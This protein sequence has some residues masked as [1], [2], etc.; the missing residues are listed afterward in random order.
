ME[1]AASQYA[2]AMDR[3]WRKKSAGAGVQERSG[4]LSQ[5]IKDFSGEGLDLSVAEKELAIAKSD[6]AKA[7]MDL[8]VSWTYY[9]KISA[10]GASIPEKIQLL[11][12][13]IER[14]ARTGADLTDVKA[15][16]E[17]LKFKK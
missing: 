9:Q 15:E 10:R 2:D 5:I 13:M 1:Q 14:F 16:L 7:D 6:K 3:Y 17:S 11:S 4:I 12:R 8:A